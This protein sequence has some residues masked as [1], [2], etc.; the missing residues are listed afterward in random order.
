MIKNNKK[1]PLPTGTKF[2][3]RNQEY[4]V[5]RELNCFPCTTCEKANAQYIKDNP[6]ECVAVTKG[7]TDKFICRR[8]CGYFAYPKRIK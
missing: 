2:T 7:G 8:K 6:Y 1:Y 3:Y 4:I 5:T